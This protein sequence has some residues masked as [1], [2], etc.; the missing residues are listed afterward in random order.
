MQVQLKRV[1]KEKK[2]EKTEEH[3]TTELRKRP[4]AT[5]E[6]QKRPSATPEPQPSPVSA[7]RVTLAPESSFEEREIERTELEQLQRKSSLRVFIHFNSL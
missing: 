7:R 1:P 2:V 3:E 5:P 6:P 4:S